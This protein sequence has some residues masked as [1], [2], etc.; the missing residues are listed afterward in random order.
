MLGVW[1][2]PLLAVG[3]YSDQAILSEIGLFFSRLAVV[4]FGGAYAVLAYLGQ[5]VVNQWGWLSAGEMMDGLGLAETTPGPLILVTEFVGYIAAYRE[6]GAA[7]GIAGAAVTLWATFAPCFLWIFAGAPY[8]EWICAQP[9]LNSALSAISAAVV[10]VILNLSLWF[11]LHVLF[12]EVSH[13][14][15]GLLSIWK[16]TLESVDWRVLFLTA[17]CGFLCFARHWSIQR[18]LLVSSLSG[19]VVVYTMS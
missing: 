7:L 1:W 5:D 3:Y 8:I 14:K 18:V 9:R 2:L 12:S 6:G 17:L 15:F 16:P 10:G 13:E 11:A 19:L 4:T